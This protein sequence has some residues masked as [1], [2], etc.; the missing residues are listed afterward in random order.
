MRN[1]RVKGLERKKKW[2]KS[3]VKKSV[4]RSE[5]I[6]DC[7]LSRRELRRILLFFPKKHASAD[8]P[9]CLAEYD[10]A[11]AVNVEPDMAGENC[12]HSE[13]SKNAAIDSEWP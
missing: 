12:D 2:L 7:E 3:S 5:Q 6:S 4:A 10:H 8:E 1:L 13:R 11:K 9:D